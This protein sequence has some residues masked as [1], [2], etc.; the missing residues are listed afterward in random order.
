VEGEGASC[1]TESNAVR[2]SSSC[3]TNKSGS[4][5]SR[6]G[7]VRGASL[8]DEPRYRDLILELR[9]SVEYFSTVFED[10]RSSISNY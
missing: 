1:G 5:A 6:A 9:Q 3:S 10:L 4:I 7:S 2:F 8:H